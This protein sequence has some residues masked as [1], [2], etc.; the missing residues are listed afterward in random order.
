M[1]A[2]CHERTSLQVDG[3]EEYI[4]RNQFFR[5]DYRLSRLLQ[6]IQ[7]IEHSIAVDGAKA[8]DFVRR[9]LGC[10]CHSTHLHICRPLSHCEMDGQHTQKGTT[11]RNKRRGQ[12]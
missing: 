2:L 7:S 3:W 6:H 5:S 4:T 9:Q 8:N 12:Y 10:L 1:A 11:T